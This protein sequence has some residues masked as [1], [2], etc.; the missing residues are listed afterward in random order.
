MRK[1]GHCSALWE[2]ADEKRK[3]NILCAKEKKGSD[4]FAKEK[5][6]N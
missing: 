3:K 1:L 2:G 5:L 4:S 6:N